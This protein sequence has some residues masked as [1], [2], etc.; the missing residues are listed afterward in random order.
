MIPATLARATRL[1]MSAP[2]GPVFVSV[3]LDDWRAEAGEDV[4]G[5]LGRR[6]SA[7]P[8]LQ[9]EAIA[10]LAER[11]R[12]PALLAIE[13]AAGSPSPPTIPASRGP[14]A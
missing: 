3:P 4:G 8:E 10:A 6:V 7:R 2:T 14:S 9:A 1:A 13:V 5:L 12:A 11:L